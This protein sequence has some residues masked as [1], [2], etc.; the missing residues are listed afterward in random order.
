MH[1]LM[2]LWRATSWLGLAGILACAC[3][4]KTAASTTTDAGSTADV[5]ATPSLQLKAAAEVRFDGQGVPHIR[6][7]SKTDA[8]YLQGWVT[9]QQRLFQMDDMRRQAYGTRAEVYGTKWLADDKTKRVLGLQALAQANLDWYATHHPA[10][11]AELQSYA[12]GVNAWL[13]ETKA[14]KHPRP[15]EFDRIGKDYWPAPWTAVDSLAIAKV[16]V[17]SNAFGADQEVLG[18]AASLLLGEQGFRDLFRFQPMLPTYATE[19]APGSEASFPHVG[20]TDALDAPVAHDFTERFATLPQERRSQ[21]AGALVALAQ[22]L[23]GVRGVGLGIAGGSNSYAVAGKHTKSGKTLF[24]NEFHQPIVVPNRFM[25]VHMTLENG[26]PIGLF[27]YALP[28]LPY[29]L[30]GHSGSMGFG[31]TTGFGDT[32]DL[33]AETL[34][35]AGDAVQF[36][37]AWVPIARRIETIR[38]KPDG[39]SWTL[40]DEVTITVDV[41]PH[42]GPIVNGLLPDEFAAILSSTGLVLSARWPGFSAQTSEAVAISQLWDAHTIDEA[43]TALNLF[44]GGPM[45][46]TL[47]DSKGAIGYTAAGPWPVR[48]WDL[49]KA[50]PWAPLDGTGAFEWDRIAP[51]SEALNDLRP[52]KGYHVDANGIMTAANLDGD[53]LNDGQYLQHFADLGTRA[54]RL[55]D[56]IDA[57]I[58]SPSLPSLDDVNALHGDNFSVFAVELL[59]E[60]LAQQARICPDAKDPA[61]AD[62]CEALKTLTAWDKQ[63]NLDSVGATLFNVWLTHVTQRILKQRVSGLVMGVVGGFLYSLGARDVV[64]WVK[65]RAP[66]ASADWL[67]DPKTKDVIETFGDHAVAALGTAL[68]QLREHFGTAPQSEWTWGKIH[69]LRVDHIAFDDLVQGPFPMDGGPN[70]VNASEYPGTEADGSVAKFPLTATSGPI[71]RFCTELAG[72]DTRGF[73]VLAGGQGGHVGQPHWMTQMPTWLAHGSYPTPL[74][75]AA[76]EAAAPDLLAFPAGYGQP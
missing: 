29:V 72:K 21:L 51:P 28:G 33:Y 62:A 39:G 30:G 58:H 1:N 3:S 49:Y 71:F 4:A 52:A 38:V 55:T 42:H 36:T 53:P 31:I 19:K 10:V 43:R 59:P 8:L 40:P 70:A 46:W 48:L 54:W 11:H 27:G 9:A 67:D 66:A 5:V 50:P 60:L 41:V 7:A 32:T 74:L 75:Q 56:L 22:Q 23:A 64:A 47:A 76:V 65:N 34:N 13:A 69:A 6:A 25:A 68:A 57:Q 24:C 61:N 20:K 15:T 14:G 73:H 17:L 2:A 35:P 45:N 18:V 16:I 44:D 12:A 26:D 37:G 63:Q